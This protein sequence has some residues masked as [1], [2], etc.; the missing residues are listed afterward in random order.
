MLK[1]LVKIGFLTI[2]FSIVV[3]YVMAHKF[4]HSP[5]EK[6]FVYTIES[7]D[8][9]TLVG[10]KLY[11]LNVLQNPLI[12]TTY[13]RMYGLTNIKVGEYEIQQMDTP[14]QMLQAFVKGEV[15]QYS[16]TVVEGWTASQALKA[17]HAQPKIK[18]TIDSVAQLPRSD[19]LPEGIE[20][21]EGLFSPDTYQY[22]AGITDFQFLQRA[23]KD[24]ERILAEEWRSREEGLPYKS[25]Y[26]ALIMASI[27]EKETGA[28]EERQDIAGVF[29]RRMQK[30]MRLQTDPTI[31]YGLG[32]RYQG[33]IKR[34]HLKEKTPY[35]TYVIKGLPPT[36][37]ALPGREAIYAALHPAEGKALY[38]VAMGDGRHYFSETLEEH[39]AA[40]RKYQIQ[41]RR[42]DYRS[43]PAQGNP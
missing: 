21:P 36:P 1:G 31:I 15:K 8:S 16:L 14:A 26:E 27:I 28:P 11:E 32:D 37:I 24:L 30:G 10:Q 2:L 19:L 20:N 34:K 22:P 18:K 4:L 35:N 39:T 12:W 43:S 38:F 6:H 17:I 33:N 23:N 25:A 9:L 29:V 3:S 7:G 40:V 42:A 41:K 5:L 13:A